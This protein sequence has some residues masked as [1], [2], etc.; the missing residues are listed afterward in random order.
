MT[1]IALAP[2]APFI[3]S[4]SLLGW[5]A[6][7][8]EKYNLGLQIH[9]SETLQEVEE[10]KVKNGKPPLEY[11]DSLGFLSRPVSAVHCVHITESEIDLARE[12]SVIPVYNPKSNMKL[13]SGIAPVRKMLDA[14]IEVALGTDGPASNDIIDMFEEMRMGAMIQRAEEE[15][16]S[17]IS[18]ADM[19]CMA[20]KAGAECSGIDA[21]V[22]VENKLADIVILDRSSVHTFSTE[23]NIL[24]WLVFCVKSSNVES[25]IINGSLV[26]KNR[27]ISGID[28][29][30]ILSEIDKIAHKF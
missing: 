9:V 6:E 18:A 27:I 23:A 26:M 12:R 8:A 17:V 30:K 15:N 21:G 10:S 14:G 19:F 2:S 29:Q 16:S 4:E 20:T 22:I 13:G 5:T 7:T 25:V 1:H 3:C 24:S 28:E 11:L